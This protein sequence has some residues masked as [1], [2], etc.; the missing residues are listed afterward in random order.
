M[1]KGYYDMGTKYHERLVEISH[2]HVMA[3]HGNEKPIDFQQERGFVF[4]FMFS[5][6]N[7]EKNIQQLIMQVVS[8]KIQFIGLNSPL[9][10]PV[11]S[12]SIQLLFPRLLFG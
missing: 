6:A 4:L 7:A 3:I 12:G 10:R 1:G 11:V 2:L 8:G 9:N 5:L